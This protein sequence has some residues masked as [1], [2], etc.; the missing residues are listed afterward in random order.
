MKGEAGGIGVE[1]I[2]RDLGSRDGRA[3][4][5]GVDVLYL[6]PMQRRECNHVRIRCQNLDWW[7]RIPDAKTDRQ[8]SHWRGIESTSFPLSNIMS[9]IVTPLS[10]DVDGDEVIETIKR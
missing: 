7:G 1:R 2:S 6:I 8:G 5:L 3:R 10:C 9:T 4:R